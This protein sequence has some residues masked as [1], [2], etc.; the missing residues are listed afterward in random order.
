MEKADDTYDSQGTIEEVFF[1]PNSTVTPDSSSSDA[2]LRESNP[3]PDTAPSQLG[4]RTITGTHATIAADVQ[5]KVVEIGFGFPLGSVSVICVCDALYARFNMK[6]SYLE[7]TLLFAA[8]SALYG[9]A[10]NMASLI[11]G[12][13]I[14]G[15]GGS[16]LY[17]DCLNLFT[18]FTTPHE[19]GVYITGTAVFT[20][21]TMI[22][23]PSINPGAS[24]LLFNR[25]R[26][27]DWVG[28]V[29][30]AGTWMAFTMAFTMAGGKWLWNDWVTMIVV[31]VVLC[32]FTFIIVHYIPIYFQFLH[33]D[34]A[35]DAAVRLL[36]YIVVTVLLNLRAGSLVAR[37]K[38]YK[39]V[40]CVSAVFI[41]LG[42]VL[43]TVYLKPDTNEGYIYG[44]TVLTGVGSGLTLQLSYAVASLRAPGQENGALC[45]Q[46]IAQIGGSVI[47]LVI[48]GQIYQ[49]YARNGLTTVLAGTGYMSTDIQSIVAG[50]QS[51]LFEDLDAENN[52]KIA[53]IT[54]ITTAMQKVSKVSF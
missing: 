21:V 54:A 38:Y 40:Y 32:H 5:S 46:N 49:T 8:G 9:A 7:S 45:L 25:L 24:T 35:L 27:L 39:P 22:C 16:G 41:V 17:M 44:F 29:L 42:G 20:P 26:R 10:P 3:K 14:A 2:S 34:S 6:W 23:M 4:P 19:R 13:V 50:A 33:G 36:P 18:S 31:F 43:L 28:F 47:A 30:E 15:A 11:V 37:V 1:S 48:A 53:A 51:S 52:L 12:R